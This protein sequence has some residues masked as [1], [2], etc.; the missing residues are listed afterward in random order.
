MG[1]SFSRE[2]ARVFGG[3]VKKDEEKIPH[4]WMRADL[5]VVWR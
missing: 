2:A 1:G 5:W 4:F 3:D